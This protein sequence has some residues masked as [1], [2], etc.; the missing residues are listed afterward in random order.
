MAAI[1]DQEV[2]STSM[3]QKRFPQ[4]DDAASTASG[5]SSDQVLFPSS[6]GASEVSSSPTSPA[7]LSPDE[8]LVPSSES[9]ADLPSQGS[10]GHFAGICSRCCFHA[11]GRCQNGRDCRFCH[12]DHE[13]RQRKKKVLSP[14][15]SNFARSGYVAPAPLTSPAASMAP[16]LPATPVAPFSPPPGLEMVPFETMSMPLPEFLLTA[17]PM[18]PAPTLPMQSQQHDVK[19]WSVERVVDWLSASGLGHLSKNFEEHRIT[20]DILLELS[21]SD[22]E[23][24]GICAFGDKKRLLRGVSQLCCQSQAVEQQSLCP[25]PPPCWEAVEQQFL[26]PPPPPC[27]E[28][29]SFEVNQFYPQGPCPP[30][31]PPP[32][33]DFHQCPPPAPPPFS[34]P[35]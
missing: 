1:I 7:N 23:E 19:T 30:P 8:A 25:P 4:D 12:F 24:I 31:A 2:M 22:I 6:P 16:M 28:A 26:C 35:M 18:L 10:F 20:G 11:K 9:L 32:F 5:A 13:K 27:W 15:G 3:F 34:A 17:P 14:T 29:P 33:V 21:P